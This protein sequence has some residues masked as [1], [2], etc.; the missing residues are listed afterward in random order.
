MGRTYDFL[1]RKGYDNIYTEFW[2]PVFVGNVFDATSYPKNRKNRLY[3][4]RGMTIGEGVIENEYG[5]FTAKNGSIAIFNNAS[6]LRDIVG[7]ITI[8]AIKELVRFDGVWTPVATDGTN[9]RFV[10]SDTGYNEFSTISSNEYTHTVTAPDVDPE[11]GTYV[12]NAVISETPGSVIYGVPFKIPTNLFNNAPDVLVEVGLVKYEGGLPFTKEPFAITF[13]GASADQ[14]HI[15]IELFGCYKDI[16]GVSIVN[17]DYVAVGLD[18]DY[19]PNTI[20]VIAFN[21]NVGLFGALEVYSNHP[22]NPT[23]NTPLQFALNPTNTSVLTYTNPN[24]FY[25]TIIVQDS[26]AGSVEI[27]NSRDFIPTGVTIVSGGV[28]DE[29]SIPAGCAGQAFTAT[30]IVTEPVYIPGYGNCYNGDMI[31]WNAFGDMQGRPWG[32]KDIEREVTV[33]IGMNVSYHHIDQGSPTHASDHTHDI[34][35]DKH[36]VFMNAGLLTYLVDYTINSKK[37]VLVDNVILPEGADIVI[38]TFNY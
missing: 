19:S 25:S 37:I 18:V 4:I 8:E 16:T 13:S 10:F 20:Y 34:P 14:D 9:T 36:L 1:R 7:S 26:S 35:T 32:R 21:P 17:E 3:E 6:K 2:T 22:N 24:S 31:F 15:K 23:P 28:F 33:N 11:S 5:T 38:L 29:D 30:D 12:S 27:D